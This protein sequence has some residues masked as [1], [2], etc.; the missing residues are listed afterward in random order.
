M[1]K[2]TRG[3][4]ISKQE[5]VDRLFTVDAME[6]STDSSRS[7]LVNTLVKAYMNQVGHFWQ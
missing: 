1:S 3:T 5:N 2:S 6:I 7:M 4:M